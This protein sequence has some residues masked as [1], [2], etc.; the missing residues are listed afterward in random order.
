MIGRKPST[1][2]TPP[3]SPFRGERGWRTGSFNPTAKGNNMPFDIA[4]LELED[5]AILTVQ[6]AAGTDDLIGADGKNPITIELYGSG[7]AQMIKAQHKAGQAAQQR[8]QAMIRGKVDPKAAEKADTEQTEKLVACT[9]AIHN[10]GDLTATA[11]YS[12]PKL[13]Y[14]TRQ[15]VKFLDDDA[16]F[17]K[18]STKS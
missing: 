8:V 18:G 15:V 11:L 1:V 5:T 12:N 4:N 17:A 16:N 9:K 3:V 7:S 10:L 14:I 2:P 13:G 6:N